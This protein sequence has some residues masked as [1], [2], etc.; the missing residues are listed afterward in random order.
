MKNGYFIYKYVKDSEIIYIGKTKRP[1]N[2]RINEHK[3][4]LPDG[5]RIY[6]FEC[7]SES[8]M[9]IVE[10]FLIDK[11]KPVCNKDCND[12]AA[13]T[14]Y[15]FEEPEWKPID[16]YFAPVQIFKG[17]VITTDGIRAVYSDNRTGKDIQKKINYCE[18]D[19]DFPEVISLKDYKY[20]I[21]TEC[22][23]IV[24]NSFKWNNN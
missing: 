1:L 4:D 10:L 13:H 8:D 14:S 15:R 17:H 3:K 24:R 19:V 2:E 12:D 7:S 23:R 6:Y 20:T 11:Y 9:N 18:C 5:C 21:C 16:T 22:G